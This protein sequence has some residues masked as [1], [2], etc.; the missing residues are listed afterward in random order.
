MAAD[1]AAKE[2]E[3]DFTFIC[4]TELEDLQKMWG[5]MRRNCC[6]GLRRAGLH[7]NTVMRCAL[8]TGSRERKP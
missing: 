2:R 1:R 4:P 3:G 6:G 7:R 8:Q 5:E